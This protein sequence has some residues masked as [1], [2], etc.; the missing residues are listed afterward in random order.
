MAAASGGGT[1]PSGDGTG[2]PR[3][4]REELRADCARCTGLCCVGPALTVSADFALAV[5]AGVPCPNL[6][7]DSRCGIHDQLRPR[8][9]P[10]CVA[11]DCFGAG[12]QVSRVTFGR[13]VDWREGQAVA[14]AA[15]DALAVLRAVGEVRWYLVEAAELVA[16]GSGATGPGGPGLGAAVLALR[17]RTAALSTAGP[18]VLAALDVAALRGEAGELLARVSE[19]ARR[20]LPAGRSRRGADLAGARL[21]GADLRG[22]DLRGALLLGADLRGADLRRADLLG[23]DLRGADVSG[24]DLATALF[25]TRPQVEAAR[26]DAATRLPAVLARPGHWSAASS[27]PVS[28]ARPRRRRPRGRAG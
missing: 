1:G 13:A 3:D 8:G 4:G 17:E 22:V 21:R 25:L 23:A 16:Q 2:P 6:L 24:A 18:E 5:P 10:G 27:G 19:G 20:G 9:F 11:F 14:A 15:F 26:G 7:A 12:Q 28:P